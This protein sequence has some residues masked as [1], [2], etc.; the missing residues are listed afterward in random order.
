MNKILTISALLGFAALAA[1]AGLLAGFSGGSS[2]VSASS[3][4]LA[5]NSLQPST[6]SEIVQPMPLCTGAV[7]SA[8]RVER[9]NKAPISSDTTPNPFLNPRWRVLRA[10]LSR[11]PR[12]IRRLVSY[13]IRCRFRVIRAVFLLSRARSIL[14]RPETH[15]LTMAS[16]F[17]LRESAIPRTAKLPESIFKALPSRLRPRKI[18]S[19][20]RT[21]SRSASRQKSSNSPYKWGSPTKR[22]CSEPN[23]AGTPSHRPR[24][25]AITNERNRI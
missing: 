6:G 1:G 8:L 18:N 22:N 12:S 13:P 15:F 20:H 11:L 10:K 5:S 3:P 16:A 24:A 23:G 25:S 9:F 4:K 7:P 19:R 17:R 14:S 2:G 21:R